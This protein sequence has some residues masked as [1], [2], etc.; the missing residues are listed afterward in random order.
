MREDLRSVAVLIPAWNPEA[1]LLP[2]VAEL[3]A[4]GFGLITVVDD[5]SRAECQAIFAALAVSPQVEVLHHARN[6]GKGRAL[7]TGFAF[8]IKQDPQP[9]GVVTADADGQHT[10]ED[11]QSVAEALVKEKTRF[12]LGVRSLEA[13]NVPFR[14]RF[15]NAL[16][17]RVFTLITGVSLRDTQTG[18]RGIPQALL[19]ELL[20]LRGERYEYEMEMLFHLCR[21]DLEAPVQVPIA[22][23]YHEENR[24]SHFRLV[25]DS[26][27]I[28]FVLLRFGARAW[29]RHNSG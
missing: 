18:L 25:R 14:S 29:L 23:V 13:K 20:R 4:R 27:R 28:G 21:K 10:P 8:V 17:R 6:L 16:M 1:K 26:L 19:P 3:A 7:K 9:L 12:V 2:L 5:G 15:G 22:S 11:I 24:G